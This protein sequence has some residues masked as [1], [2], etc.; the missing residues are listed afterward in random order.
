MAQ[1]TSAQLAYVQ[2]LA[3]GGD[4]VAQVLLSHKDELNSDMVAM[5]Q[6]YRTGG[7]GTGGVLATDLA[8]TTSGKGA[9][10]V[11]VHATGNTLEVALA[12]VK[13]TA[14][15]ARVNAFTPGTGHA[16]DWATSAPATVQAALDRMS[17]LLKTLNSDTAIP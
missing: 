16:T 8:A 15:A 6:D 17:S 9:S 3:A 10:L 14:D 11:G 13:A 5:F 1:I 2:G 7:A 12:A 4:A